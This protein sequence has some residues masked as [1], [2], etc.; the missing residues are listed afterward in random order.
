VAQP[1]SAEATRNV[2]RIQGWRNDVRPGEVIPMAFGKMRYAP[3]FAATSWTE[4]VGD[5]QYIRALFSFGYPPNGWGCGCEVEG[6][7]TRK[8]IIRM[9]GDPDKQL[10]DDWDAIDLRTGEPVGIGRGWGYPI[11]TEV[12]DDVLAMVSKLRE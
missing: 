8:G 6:A 2:Y 11:G 9:G 4:I 10:P 5:D 1:D 3:P 7:N 12:R